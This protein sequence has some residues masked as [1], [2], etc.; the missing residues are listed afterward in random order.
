MASLRRRKRDTRTKVS[1]VVLPKGDVQAGR[2]AFQDLKCHVCHR[3]SGESGFAAPIAELRGP[4]LNALLQLQETSDIAAAIIAPS[5]S[6][7]IRTSEAV[8]AQLASRARHRWAIQSCDDRAPTRRPAVVSAERA[9]AAPDL[10][11]A[12]AARNGTSRATPSVAR[13][14]LPAAVTVRNLRWTSTCS[15]ASHSSRSRPHNREPCS[16]VS[17][18]PGISMNSLLPQLGEA[19]G[20]GGKCVTAFATGIGHDKNIP[21]CGTIAFHKNLVVWSPLQNIRGA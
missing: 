1:T 19:G 18:K 17:L 6:L 13:P 2:K 8:K 9:V 15:S 21:R 12:L 7:S 3:V 4:D 10:S 14:Y 5:H 20:G 16:S 11:E